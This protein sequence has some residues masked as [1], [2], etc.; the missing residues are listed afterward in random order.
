MDGE[1]RFL[2]TSTLILERQT[3]ASMDR[4]WRAVTEPDDLGN[5]FIEAEV[6]L[7]EGGRFE[8]R[9]AWGGRV[10]GLEPGRS[11]TYV[12]DA[13]GSSRFDLEETAD[14]V[15]IVLTDRMGPRERPPADHSGLASLQPG[16][17]GSH[18]AGVVAGWHAFMNALVRHL[19]GD[20]PVAD[21]GALTAHYAERLRSHFDAV[22]GDVRMEVITDR[23]DLLI[24]RQVLAPGAATPW[25]TDA[26]H[27]FT[28]VVRGEALTIEFLD[29][30]ES[31]QVAVQ[32]GLADWEG[33]EPRVHRAVNTGSVTFE[34]VVT[35][36]RDH[37]GQDPQPVKG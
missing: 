37:P 9:N 20:A 2:G 17:P 32:P 30:D 36:Y 6:D 22:P 21:D 31:L 1:A 10:T 4:A 16:G 27:R 34:E 24:R 29:G 8:F 25:H 26:C 12:A 19:G 23:E 5:W 14:G 33:P 28:V 3:P 15:S 35:F 13:G 11:V 18:W 7:R